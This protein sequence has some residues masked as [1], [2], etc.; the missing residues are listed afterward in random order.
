MKHIRRMCYPVAA[1]AMVAGPLTLFGV[2]PADAARADPART[3]LRAGP[4]PDSCP[5]RVAL[6]NGGFERPTVTGGAVNFFPDASQPGPNSVP[7]W[8]TTATDHMIELWNGPPNPTNTPPAEGGQFAELNANEVSTLYQDHS[9]TPGTKL[10]W[11]LS[12][13]GRLGVD[14]MA[15][16]IGA[17]GAPVEQQVMSDGTTAWGTYSGVYT[18]PADQTITRFGFRSISAA[19]G[20]RGIGNFLDDVFFGTAPCVVVTKNAIPEGPVDVGDVVTYRL[21]AKNKGGGA[22][23]NVRLTDAIPDGTTYLPGSLRVV[24]GPNTGVK[25]DQPGDDQAEFVSRGNRVSFTLGNGATGSAPGSL[26]NTTALPD[27]TT[28]EFRVRVDRAAAGEQVVNQGTVTYDNLL[29]ST[30]EPLVSTSGEAVTRVNPAVDLS[31]VKSADLTRTTVGQT[32][33]YRLAVR[34][35]GPNDAHGV[36]VQDALPAGLF[37]V[38]ATPSAGDYDPATGTWTV[39]GLAKDATATLT[40]RAKATGAGKKTNTATVSGDEKDLDPANDTDS[41][42]ICVDPAPTCSKCTPTWCATCTPR[43]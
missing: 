34:N 9:T 36:T 26:P 16:D 24:D 11:R 42:R 43:T 2:A 39:G 23:E 40:I 4:D 18:V 13:R 25:T 28:V 30:P 35:V 32:V 41:V 27:G 29:G 38:S 10:Y 15:L 31:V 37:L 22:A 12:H 3:A 33:T 6:V 7:G 8:L 1:L 21:T 19:G 20:N 5:E 14:T 17:P